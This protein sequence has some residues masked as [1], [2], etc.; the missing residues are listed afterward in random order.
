MASSVFYLGEARTHQSTVLGW[1]N[2]KGHRSPRCSDKFLLEEKNLL[3]VWCVVTKQQ[4]N[5]I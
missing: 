1:V 5:V 3:L 4:S 2:R